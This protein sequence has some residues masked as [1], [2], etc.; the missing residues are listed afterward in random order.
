[1]FYVFY[2]HVSFLWRVFDVNKPC[3]KWGFFVYKLT[4]SFLAGL[5]NHQR[6]GDMVISLQTSVFLGALCEPESTFDTPG[7]THI[8][9]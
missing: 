3:E 7:S 2:C 9:G 5:L 8:A 1:M 6:Y 4:A